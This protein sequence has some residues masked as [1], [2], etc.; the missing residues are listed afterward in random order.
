MST[1]LRLFTRD[2][3]DQLQADLTALQRA[4]IELAEGEA[5]TIMPGMTHM[6]T[7]QPVT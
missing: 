7:A 3:I 4:L 5:E 6:Q 1:D 2:A